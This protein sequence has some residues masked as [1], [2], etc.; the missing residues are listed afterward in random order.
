[1]TTPTSTVTEEQKRQARSIRFRQ[2][3]ALVRLERTI[4]QPVY[5]ANVDITVRLREN[6]LDNETISHG[7]AIPVEEVATIIDAM[8]TFS[9][10]MAPLNAAEEQW[11]QETG[12]DLEDWFID[13]GEQW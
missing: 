5:S 11:K 6:G 10:T 4:R 3:E 7:L 1:M 8:G 2:D 12:I 13:S 9:A